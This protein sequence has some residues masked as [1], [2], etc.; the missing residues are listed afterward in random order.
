MEQPNIQNMHYVKSASRVKL[1][2]HDVPVEKRFVVLNF[3]NLRKVD[4]RY[5]EHQTCIS[6]ELK[7]LPAIKY[8]EQ[9]LL[10]K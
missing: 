6:T 4:Y 7:N 10:K 5:I 1:Y 2:M 8:A 9:Y 3:L